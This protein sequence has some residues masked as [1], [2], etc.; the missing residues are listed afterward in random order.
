MARRVLVPV[1]QDRLSDSPFVERIW[2]AHSEYTGG[3][4]SVA[5]SHWEMV[6]TKLRGKTTL[7]VRGPETRPTAHHLPEDGEWLG[8]RFKLG[9]FIPELLPS[10]LID[11]DLNLPNASQ[12]SFWL[13]GSSWDF[14][15]FE[16][17]D[18][19]VQRLVR[20]GVL[21]SDPVVVAALRGELRDVSQL[22]A[23][24]HFVRTTGLSP[25]TARQ[26]ER[27]RYATILLEEGMPL[28]DVAYEAGYFDQPHLTRSLKRF[29]D[30]TPSQIA[31]VKDSL[32][33]S[34]LY[35]TAP[36]ALGN[37]RFEVQ[38]DEKHNRRS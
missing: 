22:T 1:Q 7:T 33:L 3:F 5:M 24:R 10:T 13:N 38:P 16:N 6:V 29:M 9:T 15:D 14:P 23:R 36:L 11:Q 20:E 30:R 19:F 37:A 26:I 35:K 21:V 31:G 4:T 25:N 32:P 34:F 28:S 2:H 17:A 18:F 12:R 27:A 8:I